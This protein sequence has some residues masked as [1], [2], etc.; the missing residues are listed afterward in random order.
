MLINI[1]G[2]H[3]SGLAGAAVAILMYWGALT[4]IYDV[5]GWITDRFEWDRP[6][7]R[8]WTWR[9][10]RRWYAP[11]Q[12]VASD[13]YETAHVLA[14]DF[15]PEGYPLDT[16]VQVLPYREDTHQVDPPVWLPLAD[17]MPAAVGPFADD[18]PTDPDV[19]RDGI[20]LTV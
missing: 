4:I 8:P 2:I 20:A 17:L 1:A 3:L 18:D 15:G 19:T 10:Y 16:W 7:W 12:T 13:D 6:S 11:C 5:K 14:V 9:M